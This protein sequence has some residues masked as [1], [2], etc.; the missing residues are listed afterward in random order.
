MKDQSAAESLMGHLEALDR[1]LIPGSTG[2]YGGRCGQSLAPS[3][4]PAVPVFRWLHPLV[5][6]QCTVTGN[7]GRADAWHGRV[8]AERFLIQ[9]DTESGPFGQHEMSIN[10]LERLFDQV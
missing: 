9:F 2:P 7:Y 5:V 8:A 10:Q 4:S 1:C 6:P 3:I